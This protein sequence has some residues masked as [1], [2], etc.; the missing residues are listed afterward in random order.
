MNQVNLR[1]LQRQPV[2]RTHAPLRRT[3]LAS[4]ANRSRRTQAMKLEPLESNEHSIRFKVLQ[5]VQLLPVVEHILSNAGADKPED[6]PTANRTRALELLQLGAVYVGFPQKGLDH[7]NWVRS[8]DLPVAVTAASVP[9]GNY[10]RVHPRP[11]RYPACYCK[12]WPSRVLH[13]DEDY[14]LINK[15]AGLPCMRH[16]SNAAEELAAC[17]G[18]ALGL[19][20]LEVCHRLD[21]W[22]TGLVVLSRHKAANT[23]FKRALQD[24]EPGLTKTYKALSYCAP[25]PGPLQHHMYDGPFNEAAT[26][27]GPGG[28]LP[29]RGPRL[30]SACAHERWRL[31]RLVVRECREHPGALSWYHRTFNTQRRQGEEQEGQQAAGQRQEVGQQ[32]QEQQ[33]RG[34]L[35]QEPQ[36]GQQQ[37]DDAQQQQ[38]QQLHQHLRALSLSSPP[39][40][41]LHPELPPQLPHHSSTPQH[42]PQHPSA[43]LPSPPTPAAARTPLPPSSPTSTSTP[44]A[45]PPS[46][47]PTTLFESTIELMTGRTHQIRA[48]LSAVGSPL[49]GD[50]MY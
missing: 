40:P 32:E 24:R 12:D 26:V 31:C 19:A 46:S 29:P 6:D 23:A 45:P 5:D 43:P 49:V 50:Y 48:Q 16:E 39:P 47:P 34:L 8:T 27:L 7:I 9:V 35:Q 38:H 2:T 18:R 3:V 44:P 15:P 33:A 41:P 37:Q 25:P 22:T 11:K 21:Q 4:Q 20:G 17:V 30:L 14:L 13:C 1:R 28:N 42:H 36:Q 10:V